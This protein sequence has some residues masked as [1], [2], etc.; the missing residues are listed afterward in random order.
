MRELS[1]ILNIW[2]EQYKEQ[3]DMIMVYTIEAHS[4]NW[5]IGSDYQYN[6]PKLLEDRIKIIDD[7]LKIMS[8]KL[9]IYVDILPCEKNKE[10]Q[11]IQVDS[12]NDPIGYN[13]F[14]YHYS[15]WPMRLYIINNNKK[16]HYISEPT[17]NGE[18]VPGDVIDSLNLLL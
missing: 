15:A 4:K 3:V 1:G 6:Q 7:M 8:F 12:F 5:N 10:I 18:F 11:N 9:P 14:N 16:L 17:E 13:L 2:Y